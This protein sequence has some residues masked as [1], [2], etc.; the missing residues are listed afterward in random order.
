MLDFDFTADNV[1]IAAGNTYI[2]EIASDSSLGNMPWFRSVANGLTGQ[3]F[4]NRGSLNGNNARDMT[5][6]VSVVPEP[7]SIGLC[8][9][10]AIASIS[11]RGRGI[12]R[13]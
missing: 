13:A 4:R 12:Q 6:A 5:L 11:R 10:G 1:A 8:A 7:A 2:F 3:A 9:I